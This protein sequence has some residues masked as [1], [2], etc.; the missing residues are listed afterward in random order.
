MGLTHKGVNVKDLK[1][2]DDVDFNESDLENDEENEN[3][4]DKINFAGFEATDNLLEEPKA[5]NADN[6]RPKTQT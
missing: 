4:H 1:V 2:Y 5:S 3:F 6:G